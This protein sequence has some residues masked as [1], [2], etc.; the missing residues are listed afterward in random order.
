[1]RSKLLSLTIIWLLSMGGIMRETAFA[2]TSEIRGTVKDRSGEPVAGAR[3]VVKANGSAPRGAIVSIQ[4][5]FSVKNLTSGEYEVSV[6]SVGYKEQK[7]KI[8]LD[9]SQE[10]NFVLVSAVSKMDEV[11]V[12]GQG[13]GTER[14]KLAVSVE[15]MSVKQIENSTARS[16][17]QLIQGR[18]PGLTSFSATGQPGAGARIATRGIKSASGPTTPAIYIDGVRVDAGENFRLGADFG[19][20]ATSALSDLLNGDIER[21]E[22][23][24]GGAS[25]TLYGSEAANGVIQIFTKK[26][27]P[28]APK[29]NIGITSGIDVPETKFVFDPLTAQLALQQGFYQEYKA[30]ITGGAENLTFNAS[31]RMFH[32]TGISPKNQNFERVYSINGGLRATFGRNSLEFSMSYVRNQFGRTFGNNSGAGLYQITEMEANQANSPANPRWRFDNISDPTLRA[33]SR[34]R[35]LDSLANYWTRYENDEVAHRIIQSLT[36]KVSPVEGWDNRFT[37][38]AD[39]RKSETRQFEPINVENNGSVD[40]SDRENFIVTFDFLSSL[41]LPVIPE[42]LKHDIAVGAQ[43]FRRDERPLFAEGT[44][45]GLPGTS[46]ITNT[47]VKNAEESPFQIFTGGVYANYKAELLDVIF[48]ELGGR[49]DINSTFGDRIASEFF[50]KG[51]IAVNIADMAFWAPFKETIGLFKLRASYGET[52]LFPTPFTRDR[53]FISR[54]FQDQ[55]GLGIGGAQG[56]ITSIPGNANLTVERVGAL[57]IG[58]DIALAEDKVSLTFDYFNSTTRGAIFNVPVDPVTGFTAQDKNVGIIS[59]QGVE[60]GINTV[61]VDEPGV[62]NL[63]LRA[64]VATLRNR[65]ESLGGSAPFQLAGSFAYIPTRVEEGYTLPSWRINV[66]LRDA[67]GTYQ[68]GQVR[69][70]SLINGPVPTLTGN[71]GL[72]ATI[73]QNLTLSVTTEFATGFQVVNHF[74]GRRYPNVFASTPVRDAATG[75]FVYPFYQDL[76]DNPIVPKFTD[77]AR[78]GRMRYQ[79][80]DI[81]GS[82]MVDGTWFK[83]REI[84]L[85]YRIPQELFG[86]KGLTLSASLRNALVVTANQFVD[87]E[88]SFLSTRGPNVGGTASGNISPPRSF[89]FSIT[90]NFQ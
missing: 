79:R 66:P 4:G 18:V 65:V 48:I 21:V 46:I 22:F 81:S 9:A 54:P 25:S 40:R 58:T 19:G 34:Q 78:L 12:T 49:L 72:D 77:S 69:R 15:S 28:G 23:L 85:A 43:G 13:S 61:V 16:F 53:T 6:T 7:K 82:L 35:A 87:P 50:P 51:A 47:S 5:A 67:D 14:K 75:R 59:N 36:Y 55:V 56:G 90:Y 27:V 83:I 30:G 42:L 70:D 2:Q 29:Y 80:N 38:G 60:L 17:D 24:K 11:V 71:F 44:G 63:A 86:F 37:I 62:L 64:S 45:F 20:V 32:N 39:Y 10:I 33:S 84:S 1:M 68:T 52:G 89:R 57:E 31:A 76:V 41:K 88:L 26:G 74:W 8:V 3:V 73:A